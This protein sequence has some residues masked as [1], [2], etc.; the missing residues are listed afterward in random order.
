MSFFGD[1][2]GYYSFDPRFHQPPQTGVNVES[3]VASEDQFGVSH[4]HGRMAMAQSQPLQGVGDAGGGAATGGCEM[5]LSVL[6]Y[7]IF[8][9]SMKKSVL[10]Q[11]M[12]VVLKV[13]FYPSKV[14]QPQPFL[15]I[16]Q[17]SPARSIPPLSHSIHIPAW[18][19]HGHIA[20]V[21]A[22]ASSRTAKPT[23]GW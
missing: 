6:P 18:P 16:P 15:L 8:F 1:S 10:M 4:V 2:G 12:A 17:H 14:S 7:D 19:F 20:F 5:Y 11:H 9:V 21:R 22:S 23:T 13:F 3:A